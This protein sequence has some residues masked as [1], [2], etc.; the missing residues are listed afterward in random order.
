MVVIIVLRRL[1]AQGPPPPP[2]PGYVSVPGVG[3]YRVHK[4]LHTW[5]E[6]KAICEAEGGHLLIINSE[7]E[8]H[9]I[10]Q[11][12]K[13]TPNLSTWL[14][15]GFNDKEQEGFYVTIFGDPVASLGHARW[16][17]GQ[18]DDWD[19]KEDCGTVWTESGGLN[20][21]ICDGKMGFICEQ[22]TLKNLLNYSHQHRHTGSRV[23]QDCSYLVV[24]VSVRRRR[25]AW[26]LVLACVA[27]LGLNEGLFQRWSVSAVPVGVR[28]RRGAW[29]LALGLACVAGRG[30]NE[31]LFQYWSVSAVPVG[32]RRRRVAWALVLACVASL[33][34]NERLFQRWSVNQI[35]SEEEDREIVQLLKQ[36]Q[37]LSTW[38][39]IGFNDIYKEGYPVTI[40]RDPVSALDYSRW[41]RGQPDDWDKNED[42][43]SVIS[44]TGELNDIPCDIKIGFI[45]E[46]QG[47]WAL[48]LVLACVA[49]RG[50]NEGLFQRWSVSAGPV[51]VRRRRE[52][53]A[54][55]LVLA[56]VAAR[57]L[58]RAQQCRRV[59][60][61][62]TVGTSR[63]ASGHWE[64]RILLQ[65]SSELPDRGI[66]GLQ[67]DVQPS[68]AMCGSTR[69]D[70]VLV[71]LQGMAACEAEGAHLL[72]IESPAEDQAVARLIAAERD[73]PTCYWVGFH[74]MDREG[75][76]QTIFGNWTL[77]KF[78][79]N[80]SVYS[81]HV[82]SSRQNITSQL[83]TEGAGRNVCGEL[84]EP[85][86]FGE[87]EGVGV[88]S[89]RN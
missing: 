42:C 45:C 11:L 50:L 36:E 82:G 53:W 70:A 35:N 6:A 68:T 8:D 84:Q 5:A 69:H 12:L 89:K 13:R 55:A 62:V 38:M 75:R 61:S 16:H 60:A 30:L 43:G 33:G 48:A 51:G 21:Y 22:Q 57:G 7:A 80:L 56:C 73:Q 83:N 31:G 17:P 86:L 78:E 2:G 81:A 24:S 4:E 74:D 47:A 29:A 67:L 3:F 58:V 85:R 14:F 32:V 1:Q 25:V 87:A 20:D 34:L 66:E 10:L 46:Q 54:L 52:A 44:E 59:A 15:I 63:N 76:Y 79:T 77:L 19:K 23:D 65:R 9:A 41:H 18:P 39:S 26:A 37:N 49:G 72:L 64:A 88:L 40:F 27:S 71:T 28:R